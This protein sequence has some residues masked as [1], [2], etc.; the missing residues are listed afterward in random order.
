[1]SNILH[2][3]TH[4]HQLGDKMA[5]T[6]TVWSPALD[7]TGISQTILDQI[8]L[9]VTAGNTSGVE[10]K[11]IDQATDSRR[12]EREWVSLAAAEAW[13]AFINTLPTAPVSTAVEP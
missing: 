13:I 7:T 10:V 1:M 3:Y 9:E 4:A 12:V 11:T 8:A 5:K 2:K 6:I